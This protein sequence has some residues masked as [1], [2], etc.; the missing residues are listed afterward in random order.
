MQEVYLFQDLSD[1]YE[2]FCGL[3]RQRSSSKMTPRR[4]TNA[5]VMV[6]IDFL[7]G[8][9]NLYLSFIMYCR[10]VF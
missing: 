1:R 5:I 2:H 7:K 9:S 3:I 10:C 6:C 8:V 4:S